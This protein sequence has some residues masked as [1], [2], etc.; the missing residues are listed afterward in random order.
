MINSFSGRIAFPG[1]TQY[2]GAQEGL[3]HLNGVECGST[4]LRLSDCTKETL[5]NQTGCSSDMGGYA[6]LVCNGEKIV[7]LQQYYYWH[8]GI[9][10]IVI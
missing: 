3:A 9:R 4:E 8:T 5:G 7:F 10:Q 6:Y 1:S 2:Y